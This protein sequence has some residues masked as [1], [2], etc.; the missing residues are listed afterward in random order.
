[1]GREVAQLQPCCLCT[2]QTRVPLQT[3]PSSSVSGRAVSLPHQGVLGSSHPPWHRGLPVSLVGGTA[4]ENYAAE[5]MSS[6]FGNRG[7]S[8][9]F[10]QGGGTAA[11]ARGALAAAWTDGHD[12][13]WP[14]GQGPTTATQ[15]H[16]CRDRLKAGAME[17]LHLGCFG[18]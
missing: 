4:A 17:S 6:C 12:G 14:R 5:R 10:R 7:S 11:L 18:V 1:M 2:P 13:G 15:P 3:S 8:A 9:R 16:V